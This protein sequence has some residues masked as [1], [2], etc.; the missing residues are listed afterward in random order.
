MHELGKGHPMRRM[1][2]YN[3][4][5]LKVAQILED[6]LEDRGS[7]F[8]WDD[9]TLGMSMDDQRQE[10][11]RR[12]CVNL[13]GEFPPTHPGEYCNEQGREVIRDYIKELR[14]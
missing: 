2:K 8:A 11:I 3:L 4:T 10:E 1:K 14:K 6:F 7:P 9:F 5:N 13:T 12:R